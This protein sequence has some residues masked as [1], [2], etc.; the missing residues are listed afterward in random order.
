MRKWTG[1]V[2]ENKNIDMIGRGIYINNNETFIIVGI[3]IIVAI[4]GT[5]G[6]CKEEGS[7]RS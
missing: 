5:L 6:I 2:N 3:I 7:V 1:L 4:Y